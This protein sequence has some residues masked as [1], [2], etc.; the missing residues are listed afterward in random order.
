MNIQKCNYSIINYKDNVLKFIYLLLFAVFLPY[1]LFAQE[2]RI[3]ISVTNISLQQFFVEI[4]KKSNVRFSYVDNSLDPKKDITLSV[5]DESVE[6]VLNRVL[7]SKGLRYT[8]TG[9]TIAIHPIQSTQ[10]VQE[11]KQN[12][13]VTGTIVDESGEPI[14]GINVVIKGTTTGQITDVNGKYTIDV[15]NKNAVLVFSFIGYA[16]QEFIVGDQQSI[17]STMREELTE[18]DEVVVVGYGSVKKRDLTG[19]VGSLNSEKITAV[20]AKDAAQAMQGRVPG[21]FVNTSSFRPGSNPTVL[22]RGKRS[23]SGS[24]DPLYVLDGMPIGGLSDVSPGDIE[25]IDVLKDASATAIYG[26]RGSNGVV[27]ITTKKGKEGKTQVDYN[28]YYGFQTILNQPQYMNGAEFAE[29]VRESYRATGAYTSAGQDKIL[30]FTKTS[31]SFGGN[32]TNQA[33]QVNFSNPTDKHTWE[34]IAMAYDANGNYDP[35]KV[36]SGGEWWKK[37]YR[38]GMVTDHQLSIRGGNTKTQYVFSGNYYKE[39]GV[40][41]DE[42]F[43]RYMVRVNLDHEISKWIKV[44]AQTQF[45]NSLQNR[46]SSLYNS[47]RVTPLG[48]FYDDNGDLLTYVSGTDVIYFNPLQYLVSD[49]VSKPYKVNRFIGNYYGEIKFPVEGLKFRTNLGLATRTIQD[50]DFQSGNARSDGRNYAKN[51]TEAQSNYVW[52]NMLF[53]NKEIGDH[54]FTLTAMQSIQQYKH[55]NNDITVRDITSDALLY[56][57]VGSGLSV[58]G[59][60]SNKSQWNLASFMGRVNYSYKGRYLLTVS[61]RYDGSSRLATGHQ[62]VMFPAAAFAWRVSDEDFMQNQSLINNLKV[63]VGYGVTASSEVNA[64]ETKGTLSTRYYPFINAKREIVKAIGY[65]PNRMPNY[66]LTWETTRQWNAGIDFSLIKYRVNGSVDVYLQNTK[67]LLLDRQ[68]PVVSGFSVIKSNIGNTRNKGIELSI[69]TINIERRDFTWST[70]LMLYAN[71]EE[72]VELYNGKENDSA[73]KWFIGEA[74]NVFYDYKKIGIWQD[75]PEDIEE[76]AK[77]RANG[78]NFKP[79]DIRIWD[80]GDYKISPEDDQVI[81]G[82][83]RPTITGSLINTFRYKGFDFSF[84][85]L[86]NYGAMIKNE[87]NY[88][89]QSYRNGNVKVDYWTPTNPTNEAPRPTA[90]ITNLNY[91]TTMHFQKSDFLRLRNITLGYTLPKS[92]L[93]RLS[94]S[95]CRLYALVQNPW[96]W[97]NYKGIDPEVESTAGISGYATPSVTQW[98]LGVNLSF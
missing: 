96:I 1:S 42:D 91:I 90:D 31:T 41:K 57:D 78:T 80:N 51:A 43:S 26:A 15:P 89:N 75:T 14:P 40:A 17:N 92:S 28:G 35:S 11:N 70:D 19:S 45:S 68:L 79:G 86:A 18:L 20:P 3:S 87:L 71:K 9:N 77:F 66:E 32:P 67:D 50:Y 61:T 55:E 47:W 24:S 6:T 53:Y 95:R 4:E 76:M 48:R 29:C 49:A 63:R 83:V 12:I 58:D 72:I 82:K 69:N 34:S 25:S 13:T 93:Q 22:I 39:D 60:N 8:K 88:L 16:T 94:V 38:T 62:W 85:F 54:D 44:G 21:V 52:E 23:I 56:Y 84:F 98:I 74:L 7:S 36:R 73:N 37:I 65:S 27:M 30:D 64:Y 46:G 97:T 59:I 81:Q 2:T 33:D 10:S 5:N